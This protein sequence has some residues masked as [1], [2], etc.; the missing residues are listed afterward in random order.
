MIHA[1][2]SSLEVLRYQELSRHYQCCDYLAAGCVVTEDLRAEMLEWVVKSTSY[3]KMSEDIPMLTATL[4][5]RFLQTKRGSKILDSVADFRLATMGCLYLTAKLHEPYVSISASVMSAF[6]HGM[7]SA[8]QVE[9]MELII[10]SALEWHSNPPTAMMFVREFLQVLPSSVSATMREQ[11][12]DYC[13]TQIQ[14]CMLSYQVFALRE[15]STIAFFAVQNALAS[16][17]MDSITLGHV[18]AIFSYSSHTDFFANPEN[19]EIIQAYLLGRNTHA[20]GQSKRGRRATVASSSS[21]RR[22]RTQRRSLSFEGS[23]RGVVLG[24]A[25]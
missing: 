24:R 12:Y 3:M 2:C 11:A 17:G 14:R 15:A 25:C 1:G 8:E 4:L 13:H 7:F 21:K 20:K 18:A 5:D 23:P 19:E 22:S 16:L 6:S 10:L 9:E